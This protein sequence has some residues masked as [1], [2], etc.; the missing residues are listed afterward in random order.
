MRTMRMTV[1]K[2]MRSV[3]LLSLLSVAS[4]DQLTPELQHPHLL[5]RL[6]AA[7]R[8][9]VIGEIKRALLGV[10]QLG[11]TLETQQHTHLQL[12]ETLTHCY[13]KKRGAEQ[14]AQEA[15]L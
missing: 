13:N 4:A 1:M 15:G 6:S 8:E 7:G 10:K 2:T 5:T 12:M 11:E 3:L 14:L 9:C